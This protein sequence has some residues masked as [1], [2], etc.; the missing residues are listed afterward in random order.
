MTTLTAIL[1]AIVLPPLNLILVIAVGWIL[2]RRRPRLGRAV[3]GAGL[4]A[5]YILSTPYAAS[6][7]LRSLQTYPA[8][9]ATPDT[10][11]AGAIVLLG[12][13][14]RRGAPEY[15]GDSVGG[16]TLQRLRYGA[17]LYH[18]LDLPVLVSGGTIGNSK[19]PLAEIMAETLRQEF[20]VPVRWVET[21]SHNTQENAGYSAKILDAAGIDRAFLVTQAWHM[22]RAKAAFEAAGIE[23]V[24]AP[25]SF[26]VKPAPQA[27]AFL[28]TVGG[29]AMSYYALYEWFGR[30]WYTLF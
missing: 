19:R 9:S 16:L 8:L 22:P 5:F 17:R 12:G 21:E 11:D 6:L 14:M 7:L 18:A 27:R 3:V 20:R 26:I 28:P 13:D 24:A 1:K 2:A 23:V 10:N 4:L 15:G 25:T 29:L 30:A